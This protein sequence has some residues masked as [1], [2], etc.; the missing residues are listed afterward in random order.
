M[1]EGF[2]KMMVNGGERIRTEMCNASPW[3]GLRAR[4]GDV[5][6]L[7]VRGSEL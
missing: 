6:L 4:G 1:A 2:W 3:Y 7:S 5:C